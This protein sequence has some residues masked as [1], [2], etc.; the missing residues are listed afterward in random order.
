MDVLIYPES[1][2]DGDR[3][4]VEAILSSSAER[5]RGQMPGAR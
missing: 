5:Q 2:G 3:R 4:R 1:I